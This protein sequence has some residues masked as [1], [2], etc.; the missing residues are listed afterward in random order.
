VYKN[1]LKIGDVIQTKLGPGKIRK[2]GASSPS[3]NGTSSHNWCMLTL[4]INGQA[5]YAPARDDEIDYSANG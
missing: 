4:D 1:S 3:T 5:G 2:I